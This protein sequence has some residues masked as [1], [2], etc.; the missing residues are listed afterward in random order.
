MGFSKDFLWGAASA[1]FQ[2]EG[3]YN[4]DGKGLSIWDVFG[5]EKGRILHNENGDIACDHYHKFR[6][7]V[8]LMKKIGLKSYRFSISW[9]RI[10]PDGTGKVNPKG[11]EFYS[12]LIDELLDA[13]IEPLVTIYHW[14]M[15]YS[16][17]K[18]GGWKNDEISDW[19][20]QYVK[21]LVENFSNRVKYWMTFN[22][23]QVFIGLGHLMGIH[24]PFEKNS[25]KDIVHMSKNVLLSHGKAVA[26]IRKFS[27]QN[28]KIG[29]APTGDVYLPKNT[30]K[31]EI[32]N[33]RCKSFRLDPHE[34]VMG[35][36]WW[37]DPIFLGKY[38]EGASE[39][40]GSDMYTL[41]EEEWK[42]VSQP[43]DFYG[44]NAYQATC[45]LPADPGTY[46]DYGYQ[47]CPRTQV[48]WFITP[49]VLYWSPK[50]L[51]ERYG[52]P[53]MVTENGFA[54]SD[55]VSL[56]GCVHD[57]NRIDFLHRYLRCL[58]KAAEEGIP[59]IGY[60]VWSLMDNLEWTSG[61]DPRFGIIYIDY[62]TMQRTIK[63]SGYWYRD[64]IFTNGENL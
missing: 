50:F 12:N 45:K 16:V 21:V 32:E 25:V 42:L 26:T 52:K 54:S 63:D 55:W 43:L 19:F 17:Y 38:P 3:A 24:A 60:Q 64:V 40:L 9:P 14:D 11:I 59:I 46:G 29:F 49:E 39:L 53:I 27:K 23:P 13:G 34:F 36:S 48:N 10:L 28:A 56:D 7:D 6:E 4:E 20:A 31:E 15:P 61:Y 58:K 22:E 47:G 8:A 62:R 37:A 2:I 57:N 51:Y 5:H 44:F 35:N 41:S 30:T 33:A 1:A 18:K